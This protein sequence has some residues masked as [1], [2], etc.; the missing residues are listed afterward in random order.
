[1]K[2]FSRREVVG[3][4]AASLAAAPA[5]NA[6]AK[7]QAAVPPPAGHLLRCHVKE[8]TLDNTRVRLRAYNDKVPGP[9]IAVNP[10]E[11]LRIRVKNELPPYDS[12]AWDGDHNVPHDL[13][14]TN[15]HLHGME[16]TP[17]LFEPVGTS[18]PLAQMI[19]IRPGEHKD[20]AFEIPA[21][22]PPGLY[23]YHPHHHGSTVVQAVT[24]MAGPMIVYGA[25]DQVPE[26]KAARDILLA[27]QDIGLFP[28]DETPG[29]WSY[30]PKQ[31]AIWQTF[32]GI[33]TMYN[34]A[35]GKAEPTNPPL[36][37]GFT[38]GDYPLR[39]FLLNGKPFFKETHNAS[40]PLE[41][42]PT[43][44]PVQRFIVQP[45]EVVRFRMLNANSDN[46]M[47]IVV[48]GHDMHLLALDAVNYP[49]VRPIPAYQGT[50]G[51][52][53]IL[54]APANRAE[55]LIK[56]VKTPGV[57]RIL[58]LAQSAQF[59]ASAQKTI[60]EIEVKGPPKPMPLPASLPVPDRYYPLIQ[61]SEIKRRRIVQFMGNFPGT[62]NPYVGIDFLIN[63]M[64]YGETAVPNVINLNEAEEWQLK[65]EG[66]HH[67]GSEGHPFHIHEVSFEVISTQ[68]AN[69]PPVMMPPGVI[70]DTVWVPKNTTT[71]IRFKATQF[72]GKTVFHCH[73]L[74]HEDTGMMQNILFVDPKAGRHH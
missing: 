64:Q 1:M 8:T 18:N 50:K 43:Q 21:D 53:Q 40:T 22:I 34:P 70:M 67:G 49:E 31:N 35:S 10:G 39:F 14:T 68:H 30:E 51:L 12:S 32:G 57:Y 59:L 63:N 11:T 4:A 48:E 62:M 25:I 33:V 23:W 60:C 58:Q 24:G 52:G 41:P 55:F 37:C 3:V 73:I 20:Y 7:P 5:V 46:M 44:L 13:G 72:P 28:S 65:V 61:P 54:L 38:T 16:I 19:A 74:P 15:L 2:P 47:P 66:E 56:A 42:V 29:L 6:S 69:D 27:I 26:I 36:S 17:H 71:T 9:L 45:G